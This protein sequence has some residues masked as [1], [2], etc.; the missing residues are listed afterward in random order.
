MFMEPTNTA[1]E[2]LEIKKSRFISHAKKISSRQE[3]LAYIAD[4]KMQ[5]PDARH[6]CWGYLVG[7]PQNS[8]Y[9]A[10][11]DDGEPSGT[12]GKPILS[13]I[14]H[15]NVGNIILVSVRYFGGIRLGAGGLV[16]AYRASAQ[17]ALQALHTQ[18][19]TP[20]ETIK[21]T[22][23]FH[24]EALLRKLI[25]SLSGEITLVNYSSN[26]EMLITLP[27]NSLHALQA[28]LATFNAEIIAT[29]L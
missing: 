19:Y 28:H 7:D 23:P 16:R 20:L 3:A 25:M 10:C 8:T 2:T 13:Q 9:A 21:L 27:E 22:C 18:I 5:Y 29:S 26:V 12:A 24:E 11:C 6:L 4:L 14:Q 15:A 1:C 17:K